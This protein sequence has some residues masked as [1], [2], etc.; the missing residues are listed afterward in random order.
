MIFISALLKNLIKFNYILT[1][2]HMAKRVT[3]KDIA[4][5]AGV[6]IVT[7]S[8]VLNQ[9][10]QRAAKRDVVEHIEQLA[11]AMGYKKPGSGATGAIELGVLVAPSGI[12]IYAHPYYADIIAGIKEAVTDYG[13]NLS[14]L[15]TLDDIVA[16]PGIWAD[17][18]SGGTD[19]VII[20]GDH[21]QERLTE[22]KAH[23]R[24]VVGLLNYE[25]DSWSHDVVIT[26][27]YAAARDVMNRLLQS[28]RRRILFLGPPLPRS[29]A[30][31]RQLEGRISAYADTLTEWGLPVEKELMHDC[32]FD[33]ALAYQCMDKILRERRI[34]FDAVFLG[35]DM[36]AIAAMKAIN[37]HAVTIPDQVAVVGFNNQDFCEYA[38]PPLSTVDVNNRILGRLAVEMVRI[39]QGTEITVPLKTSIPC[40]F[41]LRASCGTAQR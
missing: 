35:D 28:G 1:R 7:V 12:N 34:A 9:H 14:F 21:F 17:I 29:P 41:V 5:E 30:N 13:A 25:P 3:L 18:K 4:A 24:H 31:R 36:M 33:S 40:P 11:K 23:F 19:T 22:F 2:V 15:H 32:G 37:E 16:S 10:N 26:D 8:K 39:R 38:Y 20:V 6:S 27:L